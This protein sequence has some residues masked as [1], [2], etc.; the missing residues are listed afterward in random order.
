MDTTTAMAHA[1]FNERDKR[2]YWVD[3]RE[4]ADTI[5]QDIRDFHA[6]RINPPGDP[7]AGVIYGP[8]TSGEVWKKYKVEMWWEVTY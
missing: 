6:A 1:F 2:R 7:T 8:F 4:A 5:S 3:N